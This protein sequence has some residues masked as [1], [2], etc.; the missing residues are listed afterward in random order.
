MRGTTVSAII[1]VH[2]GRELLARAL[3]SVLGQSRPPDEVIVVDDGSE[4]GS[5]AAARAFAG[6]TCI[7][8]RH[9]GQAAALNQ[10]IAAASGDIVASTLGDQASGIRRLLD[11]EFPHAMAFI[12]P[13]FD[14]RWR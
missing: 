10:G 6:V 1:P 9:Q 4:D 13:G 7:E 14:E 5:A 12:R 2:D 8:L 3:R 11:D